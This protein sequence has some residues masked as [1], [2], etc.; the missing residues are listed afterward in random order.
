MTTRTARIDVHLTPDDARAALRADVLLGLT[1]Q[2]RKLPPK[3]FYDARGSALFEEITALPEYFPTRTEAALLTAHVDEIAGLTG[4]TTLV[5]LGSGSSAKTRLLLDALTRAGTLR[6]YVPLD[7]SVAAL[8]EAL[9]AL[10]VRYPALGLHLS[11]I[12]I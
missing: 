10:A 9:D 8:R 7:V 12:H 5:E 4:A 3:Y 1:S 11:L 2:P 6:R